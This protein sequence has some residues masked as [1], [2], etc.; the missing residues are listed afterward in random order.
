MTTADLSSGEEELL[1]W[2][3]PSPTEVAKLN[4]RLA[5]RRL[6]RQ[7]QLRVRKEALQAEVRKALASKKVIQDKMRKL[8]VEPKGWT[9]GDPLA[10]FESVFEVFEGNSAFDNEPRRVLPIE[11]IEHPFNKA[12][13]D[14]ASRHFPY[15]AKH[16]NLLMQKEPT[17]AIKQS[18]E[19][20]VYIHEECTPER[21]IYGIGLRGSV[22]RARSLRLLRI[23]R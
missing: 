1:D 14:F 11:R 23:S 3:Q 17:V 7:E 19:L 15:F 5:L 22:R 21:V 16:Y 20:R 2:A 9:A 12:V 8:Q 4:E 13:Y 6:P 10:D 18:C